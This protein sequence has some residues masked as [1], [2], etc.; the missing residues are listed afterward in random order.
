M[1]SYIM[2]VLGY[3]VT[4]ILIIMDIHNYTANSWIPSIRH[5]SMDLLREFS[6]LSG[7]FDKGAQ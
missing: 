1:F 5:T 4:M 6:R 7:F 2:F 3:L